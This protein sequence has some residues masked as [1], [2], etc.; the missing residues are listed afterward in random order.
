MVMPSTL[1]GTGTAVS[2]TDIDNSNSSYDVIT[3][4][5]TL[6]ALSAGDILAEAAEAGSGK[7]L[8]AVANRLTRDEVFVQLDGLQYSCAPVY[9]GSVYMNRIP[10]LSDLEMANMPQIH[11]S[12]LK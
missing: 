4:D 7:A 1:T 8:M 2:I 5:A 6:G 12:P 10:Q 9:F 3:V 11:F